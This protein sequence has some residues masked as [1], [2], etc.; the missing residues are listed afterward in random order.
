MFDFSRLLQLSEAIWQKLLSFNTPWEAFWY[1]FSHGG[2]VLVLLA[3]LW[4]FMKVWVYWRQGIYYGAQKY[5]LLAIDVPRENEQGPK[6]V[7]NIFSHV[8]GAYKGPNLI[9]KYWDG[10]L[11]P[12]FS[13]ELV[14]HG[15]YLQFLIHTPVQFRDLVESSIYAQYPDAEITETEDYAAPAPSTFKNTEFDMW[16]CEFVLY[17]DDW[18]PIRTYPAFEYGLTQEFKDPMAATLE[19]MG[20]IGP[21]ENMWI[22]LVVTPIP[23]SWTEEGIKL[24]KKLIGAK[25]AD[26]KPGFL[27]STTTGVAKGVLE[28]ATYTLNPPK[29]EQKKDD[30][31]PRSEMLFLS[32]G[33]RGAVEAIEAKIS[34]NAFDTK[35]RFIYWGRKPPF[36]KARGVNGMLGAIA[37][38]NSLDLNGFKPHP[39]TKSSVDYFF[40]K[41]RQH[42]RRQRLMASYKSRSNWRGWGHSI[43]N[44]EELA[45]L[46][47]FPMMD[48]RTPMLKKTQ[49][50]R[51]ESP[52]ALP[53]ENMPAQA[54]ASQD[55]GQPQTLEEPTPE[56]PAPVPAAE[57]PPT[58]TQK[59]KPPP[60]LP[61]G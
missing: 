51:M 30:N 40:V 23:G 2:W 61:I 47:H 57:T 49:S 21:E 33:E 15:G 45:T 29:E 59:A 10:F 27:Y 13:F 41:S 18:Y 22:Q 42:A 35:F 38:V 25:V 6:A 16:G 36:S 39:K 11:C 12:K 19:L 43:L 50:K 56:E 58:Q 48:I 34:K 52:F 54:Q 28:T 1:L 5:V 14:S 8:Y 46:W 44:I 7:E 24:V 9:E 4:G 55:A 17:N 37:Q 3:L 31:N 26:K 32:P 60:N 53:V 20:K